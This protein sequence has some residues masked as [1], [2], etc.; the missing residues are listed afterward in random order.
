MLTF[1]GKEE[2]LPPTRVR[3]GV[4]RTY[5]IFI[6]GGSY[7]HGSDIYRIMPESS[8][9]D[10]IRSIRADRIK[11]IQRTDP[12]RMHLSPLSIPHSNNR[13][14]HMP[15]LCMHQ[16]NPSMRICTMHA[17][18]MHQINRIDQC[19][20]NAPCIYPPIYAPAPYEGISCAH[21][22]CRIHACC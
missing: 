20:Q 12:W 8:T 13:G 7:R 3:T 10:H 22:Q 16:I 11:G 14:M 17:S 21:H 2:H 5:R 1:R 6:P 9:M 19:N 4:N 15:A 18:S